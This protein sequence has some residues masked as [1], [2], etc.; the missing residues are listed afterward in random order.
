MS[1]LQVDQIAGSTGT[2]VTIKT[3][4]T[5]TLVEDL[6]AGSAKITNLAEPTASGDA[7]TKNYVDTQLLTLDTL[8]ELS[9]VTIASVADNEVLAYDSVAAGWINQTAS[10]AGLATSGDLTSHTSDTSNPHSVTA[11]QVGALATSDIQDDDTFASASATDIASS[12][13]IKAYVDAQVASKDALSELSGTSDDVAEGSTNL[14]YSSS[15][16]DTDLATKTTDNLTE[17]STNLYYADS[18]VESYLS[19]GNGISYSSGAI[20]VDINGATDGTSITVD[21]ANDEILVYDTDAT[22]VKKVKVSQVS[23]PADIHPFLLIGA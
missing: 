15:L 21:V 12:E 1:E 3:G 17:G 13:S 4:H 11:T 7:A 19:G 22:S 23:V 9:D 2:T 14:Y 18:L 6:D 20:A 5:L 10:E 8:G 16:F